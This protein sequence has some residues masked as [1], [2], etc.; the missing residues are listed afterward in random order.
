M[1]KQCIMLN[2]SVQNTLYKISD[3]FTVG[4]RLVLQSYEFIINLLSWRVKLEFKFIF[5]YLSL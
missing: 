2:I 4:I 3:K 1:W 5:E